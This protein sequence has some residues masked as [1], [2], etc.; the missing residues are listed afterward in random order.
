MG[1]MENRIETTFYKRGYVGVSWGLM[2]NK[3]ETTC[4]FAVD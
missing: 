4:F 2:E 1:I 3:M